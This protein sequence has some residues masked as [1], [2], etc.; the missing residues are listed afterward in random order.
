MTLTEIVF[1]ELKESHFMNQR[2]YIFRPTMPLLL[3]R[4]LGYSFLVVGV[5]GAALPILPGWPG[6]VIAVLLLGRRDR[7]LRQ[8]HV[9]LRGSLRRLRR[10]GPPPVRSTGR[11][12]SANYRTM[13]RALLPHIIRAEQIFRP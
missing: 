12:L 13:R 10:T 11:Y 2:T 5:L 4:V 3:R 1:T 9:L 7:T 6:I 8:M